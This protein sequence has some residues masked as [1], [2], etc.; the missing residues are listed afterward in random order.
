MRIAKFALAII[1]SSCL[2]A[3]QGLAECSSDITSS[4]KYPHFINCTADEVSAK[5]DTMP[6]Y[7]PLKNLGCLM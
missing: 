7:L 3:A 2:H 1:A 6:I 5:L 4:E